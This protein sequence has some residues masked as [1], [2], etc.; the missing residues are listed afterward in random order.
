MFKFT[1][2]TEKANK[3]LN[4]A[5][6]A[7]ENLGHTY[8]GSEHLLLGL[9]SDTSTVAG[10][11]LANKK[12]TYDQVETYIKQTVGVG[13]PTELV[14]DDFTPRSKNIIET[15][16]SLARGMGQPLVGTEYVLLAIVREQSCVAVTVRAR[17]DQIGARRQ[18]RPRHRA[19]K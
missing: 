7:A 19:A 5:V 13:V 9:L 18:N 4:A 15:A 1:G 3:S 17:F 6:S 8:I 11:V 2:F 10:T 12:I 16:A 14:P